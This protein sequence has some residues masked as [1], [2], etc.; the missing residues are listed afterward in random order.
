MRLILL[1]ILFAVEH[2]IASKD[3]KQHIIK[4]YD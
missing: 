1:F 4:I 2:Q 3:H